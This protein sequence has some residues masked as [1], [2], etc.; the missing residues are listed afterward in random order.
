MGEFAD[1]AYNYYM[2]LEA[3]AENIYEAYAENSLDWQ[4]KEGVLINV[5][6]MSDN[7]IIN[8]KLFLEKTKDKSFRTKAW[9]WV[10]EDQIKKRKL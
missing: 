5:K 8:T 2:L 6:D 3:E 9:I 4:T 10:F 1:D 7:H